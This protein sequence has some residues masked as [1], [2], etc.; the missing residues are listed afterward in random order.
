MW[1]SFKFS[2]LPFNF[3]NAVSLKNEYNIVPIRSSPCWLCKN[4][5]NKWGNENSCWTKNKEKRKT[6]TK[7]TLKP[8]QYGTISICDQKCVPNKDLIFV[9][10]KCIVNV[11]CVCNLNPLYIWNLNFGW[12]ICISLISLQKLTR[13]HQ[14]FRFQLRLV[15]FFSSTFCLSLFHSNNSFHSFILSNFGWLFMPLLLLFPSISFTVRYFPC[16]R[17]KQVDNGKPNV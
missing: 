13:D 10:H 5:D 16:W 15:F 11:E 6:I 14:M 17:L 2:V 9:M 7:I 12:C 4:D 8:F 1:I 3:D